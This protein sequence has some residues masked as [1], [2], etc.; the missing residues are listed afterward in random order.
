MDTGNGGG[1]GGGVEVLPHEVEDIV[2]HHG[3]LRILGPPKH[4]GQ[5][6]RQNECT[7]FG[8]R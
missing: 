6:P 4:R 1:G 5:T 7:P 2:P 8:T 3:G